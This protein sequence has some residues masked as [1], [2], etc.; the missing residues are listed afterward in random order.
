MPILNV[1]ISG[2]PNADISMQASS[3]LIEL[4][5]NILGKM[6]DVIAVCIDYIPEGQWCVGG[7]MLSAQ[8][9]RSFYVNVAITEGTN[10]KDEMARYVDEVFRGFET[11]L[12]SV[13]AESYIHVQEVRGSAY[14]YGGLT[15]EHRYIA[16]KLAPVVPIP[17]GGG[18]ELWRPH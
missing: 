1:N 12:G 15:Q 9:K 11:I 13:H 4:T 5:V 6:R 10:T 17:K 18:T 16:K 8:G 2:S 3:L 14:G 7:S